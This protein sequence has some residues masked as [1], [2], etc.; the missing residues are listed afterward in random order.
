ML[1]QSEDP[2]GLCMHLFLWHTRNNVRAKLGT[3]K[4]FVNQL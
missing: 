1:P 3:Y 2:K 4:G